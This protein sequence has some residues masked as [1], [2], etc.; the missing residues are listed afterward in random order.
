MSNI[1]EYKVSHK[2]SPILLRNTQC[3]I[4]PR[5]WTSSSCG[6]TGNAI[7]MAYGNRCGFQ[8]FLGIYYWKKNSDV[9]CRMMGYNQSID[10]DQF[11]ESGLI[12]SLNSIFGYL[13]LVVLGALCNSVLSSTCLTAISIITPG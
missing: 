13:L 7:S 2:L 5:E 3:Y 12:R 10:L 11:Q 6:T 8:V 4:P 1:E 9:I